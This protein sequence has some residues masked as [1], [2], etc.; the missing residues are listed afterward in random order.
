VI[1]VGGERSGRIRE[2]VSQEVQQIQA[3]IVG[4]PCHLELKIPGT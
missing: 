3:A 1:S 4:E 2:V